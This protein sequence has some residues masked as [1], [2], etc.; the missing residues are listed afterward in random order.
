LPSLY[1]SF[2]CPS[3]ASRIFPQLSYSL[4]CIIRQASIFH[5]YRR[6]AKTN[7]KMLTPQY[8][9]SSSNMHRLASL[10]IH[11][12]RRFAETEK[13]MLA[14]RYG[15]SSSNMHRLASLKI[16]P[17]R[18]FAEIEKKMLAPRYGD[19]PQ[20]CIV[21]QASRSVR[22]G[23]SLKQ[24]KRCSLLDIKYHLRGRSKHRHP[25]QQRLR[26][27]WRSVHRLHRGPELPRQIQHL[28]H[29]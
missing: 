11:P 29:R 8:G 15:K 27:H 10:K 16:H 22:S 5:P 1:E 17:F 18:R 13:K 23:D 28:H 20:I 26:E 25:P 14:P 7:E 12:V 21:W 19:R 9:K 2:W 24:R 4:I 3:S 6:I